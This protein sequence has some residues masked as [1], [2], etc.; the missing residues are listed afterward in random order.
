MKMKTTI[1]SFK[2]TTQKLSSTP[3]PTAVIIIFLWNNRRAA[4]TLGGCRTSLAW[5]I[6]GSYDLIEITRVARIIICFKI[7]GV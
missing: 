1:A 6:F 5:P 7:S 4:A 3:A 2:F